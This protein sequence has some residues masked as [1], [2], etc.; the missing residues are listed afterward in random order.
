MKRRNLKRTPRRVVASLTVAASLLAQGCGGTSGPALNSNDAYYRYGPILPVAK[1]AHRI[2]LE[3]IE[4]AI[5]GGETMQREV[6]VERVFLVC[7]PSGDWPETAA[8]PRVSLHRPGDD[9][10][11][12]QVLATAGG[13]GDRVS[14]DVESGPAATDYAVVDLES[15]DVG[16]CEGLVFGARGRLTSLPEPPKPADDEKADDKKDDEKADDEKK[17][18]EKAD[19]E[20]PGDEAKPATDETPDDEKPAGTG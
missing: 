17:D 6:F 15:A 14:Y 9:E 7:W 8:P 19:D 2:T 1:R 11:A 3:P 4:A 20:K 13:S 18:D 16:P 10:A 5:P 12:L